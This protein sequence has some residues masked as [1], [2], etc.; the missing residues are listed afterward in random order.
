MNDFS[1]LSSRVAVYAASDDYSGEYMT[2]SVV[3]SE[4]THTLVADITVGKHAVARC[5]AA[6]R[7]GSWGDVFGKICAT[8]MDDLCRNPLP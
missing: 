7:C 2:N 6:G 8:A 1:T 4:F 3:P 5:S